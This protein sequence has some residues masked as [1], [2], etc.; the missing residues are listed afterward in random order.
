VTLFTT[1]ETTE[2]PIPVTINDALESRRKAVYNA[3]VNYVNNNYKPEDS[4][5]SV[6]STGDKIVVVISS[7]KERLILT[8]IQK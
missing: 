5:V 6:F 1:Q 4:G 2:D 3:V 7:E 8:G